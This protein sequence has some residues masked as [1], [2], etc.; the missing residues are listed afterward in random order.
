MPLL[1]DRS[2]VREFLRQLKG[3][4]T[5]VNKHLIVVIA[6]LVMM[7]MT[8]ATAT[9]GG[10][11]LKRDLRAVRAAT[12]DFRAIE[13]AT[14]AGYGELRDLDDI[15][16]IDNPGVGGMGIHYV[17]G[18]IVF[19]GAVNATT[20]EAVVYEPRKNGKLRLVA[21]EYVVIKTEWHAAN[22]AAR[23]SLF[24]REFELVP[25]GNRYGL[26]DFYELHAWIYKHNP[27]GMFEDW[28]PRVSCE[29]A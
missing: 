3:R 17:K 9:A 24:G 19:D 4:N 16:C 23:P 8:S 27:S 14:A 7:L 5:P 28:N 21:V 12:A 1:V 20:P 22:G 25:A 18:T 26:P 6:I 29:F 2:S 10:N 15:A 11:S 13:A